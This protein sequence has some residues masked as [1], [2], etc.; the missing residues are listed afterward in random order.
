MR[1]PFESMV[2]FRK[3]E[4]VGKHENPDEVVAFNAAKWSQFKKAEIGSW[5][6]H[7]LSYLKKP[8]NKMHILQ[9]DELVKDTRKGG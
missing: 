1:N 6:K 5:Y 2:S 9:Y 3:L 7:A 4:T 8:N